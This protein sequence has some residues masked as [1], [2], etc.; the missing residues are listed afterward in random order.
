VAVSVWRRSLR[1]VRALAALALARA[2][3]AAGAER[4]AA[5]LD[6]AFPLGTVLHPDLLLAIGWGGD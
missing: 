4:L 3:D 2:S 5:E 6:E 1:Y